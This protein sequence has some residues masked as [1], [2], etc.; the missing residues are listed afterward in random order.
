[1]SLRHLALLSFFA[2]AVGAAH[3]QTVNPWDDP[4]GRAA[5]DEWLTQARL[6][7]WGA[8]EGRTATATITSAVLTPAPD[9]ELRHKTVYR[10]AQ[11][12][13]ANTNITLAAY[14]AARMAGQH[15][16]MIYTPPVGHTPR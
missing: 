2:V 16:S 3:A 14:V 11:Q 1:M 8:W 13:R 9:E 5:I 6:T 4:V 15:P 7:R 12:N 10:Q